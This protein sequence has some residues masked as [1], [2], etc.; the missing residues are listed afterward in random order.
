VVNLKFD[1]LSLDVN[2]KRLFE[3][4]TEGARLNN[5]ISQVKRP[6]KQTP[7][8]HSFSLLEPVQTEDPIIDMTVN[9]I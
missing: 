9:R 6:I 1:C 7:L 5:R 4:S 3:D 2:G 8:D